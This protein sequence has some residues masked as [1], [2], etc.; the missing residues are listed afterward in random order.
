MSLIRVT[1]KFHF[2]MAHALYEYDGICRN[3]HGH[4]YNLEVT[5]LGEPKSE[6][7]HPK[8]GMVID[9]GRLKE[10]V[11]TKI[12][13]HFDH[14]LVVN[15]LFPDDHIEAFKKATERMIVVDFQPT[16]ENLLLHFAQILQQA[17]PSNVSL[18]SMRLYETSNSFAEW[19]STDNQ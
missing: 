3:I 1:R 14:A 4:T 6:P 16:T 13:K 11:Q 8:D 2:E 12:V 9:F 18:F 17:F 10:L 7:G 15:S 5:L 19:Y